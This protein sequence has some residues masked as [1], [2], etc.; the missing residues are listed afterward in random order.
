MTTE[1]LD[2]KTPLISLLDRIREYIGA[3]MY[4]NNELPTDIIKFRGGLL[5]AEVYS[6]LYIVHANRQKNIGAYFDNNALHNN[7]EYIIA[8]E[9]LQQRIS[10]F[11]PYR[12]ENNDKNVTEGIRNLYN[13]GISVVFPNVKD[14]K[15]WKAERDRQHEDENRPYL[16][17]RVF[18]EAHESLDDETSKYYAFETQYDG[19]VGPPNL[20]QYILDFQS[21]LQNT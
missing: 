5:L 6:E 17:G 11:Y 10:E 7:L 16:Y 1:T 14:S 19:L 2:K 12:S 8:I 15:I 20:I 18:R 9:K 3:C 21:S 13:N 4:S